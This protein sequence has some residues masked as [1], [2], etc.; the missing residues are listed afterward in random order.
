MYRAEVGLA[1]TDEFIDALNAASQAQGQGQDPTAAMATAREKF[2][3]AEQSLLSVIAFVPSEYDNYVFLA[4]LYNLGGQT[5]DPSYYQKA[6]EIGRKGIQV[7]PFGPA[8]RAQ[9]ARALNATGQVDEAIKELKY[10]I[11]MDPAF[12]DGALQLANI[13]VSQGKT[14]EALAVLKAAEVAKPGQAGVA[15]MIQQLEGTSTTTP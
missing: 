7:E 12:S 8:I 1:Y 11:K 14:A 13:Y 10:S 6:I 9:L 3:A 5:I 2:T 15:P 4:N